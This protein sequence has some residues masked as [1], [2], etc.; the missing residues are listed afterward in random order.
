MKD[1][2]IINE[3][4]K[5]IGSN[6]SIFVSEKI[7]NRYLVF[8]ELDINKEYENIK[9]DNVEIIKIKQS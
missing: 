4:S 1:Y 8:L 5:M 9:F 2:T 3:L 7:Y 6:K